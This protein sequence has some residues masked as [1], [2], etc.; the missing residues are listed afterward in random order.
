MYV[1]ICVHLISL[2]IISELDYDAMKLSY[3]P[4]AAKEYP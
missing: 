4:Q 1:V 2:T 3:I